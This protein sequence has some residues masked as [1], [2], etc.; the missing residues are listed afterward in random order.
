MIWAIG[1]LHL[2]HTKSKPMDIFGD[3]WA[4]HDEQIFD[5]WREKVG[6][7]DLVL[8]VGDHSWALKLEEAIPDLQEL[9]ELPGRKI[10]SKGNHD[11]WWSSLNKMNQLGFKSLDYL[12]NN[13]FIF[14]NIGIIGTRGWCDIDSSGFDEHD[15]K[16]YA[17]ELQRLELSMQALDKLKKEQDVDKVIAMIHYP[18]FSS[19]GEPNDF[20]KLLSDF[21]VD[22]CVYGHLHSEGHRFI[23]E[24]EHLGV[25]YLCV[26]SDYVDF[27]V[28]KIL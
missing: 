7:D 8:L 6:E 28:K 26:S 22:L 17:R 9:D 18:P 2:D 3:N 12:N 4:D 1:D 16:I 10:L 11:Y 24:G 5:Y 27:K 21:K 14:N 19:K 15:E 25:D 23:V 20:A 13:A